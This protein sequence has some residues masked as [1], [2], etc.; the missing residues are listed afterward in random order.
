M[1][2]ITRERAI[3]I[4]ASLSSSS[5]PSRQVNGRGEEEK[6]KRKKCEIPN[7]EPELGGT[8]KCGPSARRLPAIHNCT[9]CP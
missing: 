9:S 3:C 8:R 4:A 5:F 6:N 2:K 1:D 7:E